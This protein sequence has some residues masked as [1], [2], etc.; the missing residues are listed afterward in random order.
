MHCIYKWLETHEDCPL[1]RV[2]WSEKISNVV[3]NQP[4]GGNAGPGGVGNGG[5]MG[6]QALQSNNMVGGGG[7]FEGKF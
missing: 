3:E 6:M 2:K 1:D 5:M 4:G 7:L